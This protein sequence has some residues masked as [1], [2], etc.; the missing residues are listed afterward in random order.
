MRTSQ[1]ART[2]RR[3]QAGLITVAIAGAAIFAWVATQVFSGATMTLD[4]NVRALVHGRSTATMTAAMKGITVLGSGNVWAP[5]A[6]IAI[7]AIRSAAMRAIAIPLAVTASGA[8]ILDQI[9]K[10]LLP[11]VRPAPFF[12][13]A[14]PRFSSFPSGHALLALSLYGM[15]AWL[16]ASRL[17]SVTGRACVWTAA[18]ALILAVGFSRVYLGVHHFTDVVA[19]Y[20]AGA[21]WLSVVFMAMHG[22]RTGARRL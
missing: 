14:M 20:A 17:S 1:E 9:L 15:L 8:G 7:A 10:H 6:L 12:E 5:L 4:A 3:R 19:G 21:V 13:V 11:R 22:T 18:A 16:I 2:R